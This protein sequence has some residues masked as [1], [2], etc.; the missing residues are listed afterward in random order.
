MSEE[1]ESCD[2][3]G[4]LEAVS[5][6]VAEYPSIVERHHNIFQCKV[7]GEIVVTDKS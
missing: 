4:Q 7:C 2:H 6:D 5:A 3:D 1:I